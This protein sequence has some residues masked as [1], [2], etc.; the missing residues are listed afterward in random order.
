MEKIIKEFNI[1]LL[2]AAMALSFGCDVDDSDVVEDT[3]AQS[4]GNL[5]GYT[6]V[7]NIQSG[8]GDFEEEEDFKIHFRNSDTYDVVS[9]SGYSGNY[10]YTKTGPSSATVILTKNDGFTE[11]ISLRFTSRLQCNYVRMI[12]TGG[13]GTQTGTLTVDGVPIIIP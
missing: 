8:T 13:A 7:G 2:A 4:P 12:S 3:L 6:F 10:S 5:H 1:I 11:V 9:G